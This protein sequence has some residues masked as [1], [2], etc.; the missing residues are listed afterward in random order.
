MKTCFQIRVS[1]VLSALLL[2][3]QQAAA[4]DTVRITTAWLNQRGSPPYLLDKSNTTYILDTDVTVNGTAFLL[5]SA[6]GPVKNV[7]VDL[8]GHTIT[9]ANM[10]FTGVQNPGFEQA[11]A[12]ASVPLGWDLSHAPHAARQSSDENL[13]LDDYSLKLQSVNGVE[14][15]VLSSPVYLPAAG[16][17]AVTA[18]VRGGPYPHLRSR[19]DVEGISITCGNTVSNMHTNYTGDMLWGLICE[20]DVEAPI[21]V[22]AKVIVGSNDA[23]RTTTLHVDEMD[24]RPISD[25]VGAR[26]LGMAA[27]AP[28][29]WNSAVSE[30]KNG[31]IIQGRSKAV[32]SSA[33][34]SATSSLSQTRTSLH[35]LT[36]ITNG[37]NSQNIDEV[38]SG[39]LDIYNNYLEANGKTPLNRQYP[40]AMIDLG[41]TPGGNRIYNN[42][43]MN[44][45]HMGI[46]HGN[47]TGGKLNPQRSYIYNNTIKTRMVASNGFAIGAGGNLEVYDNKIQPIQ[48]HGIGVGRNS[49]DLKIYNN[50][51]EP[52]TWPCSEYS[53]YFYPSPAHGIRIKNYDTGSIENLEIYGNIIRG[54]TLPQKPNCHTKVTG[55]CN[56]LADDKEGQLSQ[57]V[58][59]HDNDVSVVTDDYL[60][61][62]AVAIN[63]QGQGEVYNNTFKSNHIVVE[64]S[65]SDGGGAANYKRFASNTLVKAQN[66]QPGFH[67]LRYGYFSPR[68]NTFLDT[69]LQNGASLKDIALGVKN[70]GGINK[71][72]ILT[73]LRVNWYLRVHVQDGQGSPIAGAV[74]TLVNKNGVSQQFIADTEGNISAELEEY[75]YTYDTKGAYVYSAPYTLRVAKPGYLEH[76]ETV[77]LSSSTDRT[78]LLRSHTLAPAAPQRLRLQ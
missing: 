40:F 17:Y 22:R 50:L 33:I 9:Y 69:R 72:K 48:G 21:T 37:I 5:G 38:W 67:A 32:Y 63:I 68:D 49:D 78:V 30:I 77:D 66:A 4:T 35:D 57:N 1:L 45:P 42:T 19:L 12:T 51:I 54:T 34:K 14:E 39:N 29:G 28:Y 26:K 43:L 11:G 52:K 10:D 24:I 31:R 58:K 75:D 65:G 76:T 59:I 41:R 16:R 46:N 73:H 6:A 27:I 18:E 7:T 61:Q 64:L 13:F 60:H 8:N 71:E 55:I 53:T 25:N 62:H 20:F 44:G 23:T 15:Y 47:A 74:A 56:Y 36:I 3:T 70:N 2:F